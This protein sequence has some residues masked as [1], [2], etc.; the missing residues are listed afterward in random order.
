[1]LGRTG[2][3][4]V[5]KYDANAD[6]WVQ[7]LGISGHIRCANGVQWEPSGG[8]HLSTSADRTSR[9]HAQCLRQELRSWHEFSRPQ[10]HGY[11]LNCVD[12]LGPARFVSGADEKLLRVFDEP[13][14]IAQILE[15]LSGFQQT[16]EE[17]LP[18]TAQMPVLGLSN[19][20]TGDEAPLEE[21]ENN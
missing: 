3:W 19:Q 1:S 9:L 8:Y 7:T 16:A 20:A 2:S 5:W 15:T 21:D 10:I 4:R 14:Q 18:D 11:D 17:T 13:K 6:S 12:T